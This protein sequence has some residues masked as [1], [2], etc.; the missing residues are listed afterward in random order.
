LKKYFISFV[1]I[2]CLLFIS[3]YNN[4]KEKDTI[5]VAEVAHSIFYA[6][7]YV[8]IHNGYFEEEGLNIELTL[9]SGAD[10]VTASVLSGDVDIG[11]CGSEATIYIYNSNEKDYLI[12]FAGLT[13]KDGSFIVS[14]KKIKNFKLE[15]LEDKTIIGGRTGGMPALMLSNAIN[16]KKIKNVNIDTSI[17]FSAMDGAFI[18]GYGDFVTLF[19]P[20]ALNIEKQGLGYVVASV[21]EISTTVPYTTFNARKSYINENKDTINKFKNAINKGLNYVHNNSSKEIAKIV[22]KEFNDISLEDMTKIID[23]YKKIDAWYKDS[24]IPEKDLSNMSSILN[25]KELKIDYSKLVK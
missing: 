17:A 6:P 23:R 16:K 12:N 1:L 10:K 15:N 18:G 20:N 3:F 24:N 4:P 25:D 14:R 13:K 8:A 11:F 22:M 7:F 9:A 5:K 2:F 19:E 21:G